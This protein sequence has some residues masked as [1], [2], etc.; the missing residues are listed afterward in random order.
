M[1]EIV[2][3]VDKKDVRLGVHWNNIWI[4][5][6][7]L[8]FSGD[9]S[10]YFSSKFHTQGSL[11][12]GSAVLRDNHLFNQA[13]D[14]FHVIERGL[15]VSLHPKGQLIHV[16]DNQ[17]KKI[18]FSRKM[19]WFP[20]KAPFNLLVLYSPPLDICNPE[21]DKS[22]FYTQVPNSYKDS[23]Q[24]RVDIFPK[25]T[26]EHHPFISSIWIFWGRCPAYLVRVSMNII[27]Q[28]TPVLL[29]WPNDSN[30]RL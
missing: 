3:K 29:F 10:F 6:C 27:K 5:F 1:N 19:E 4:N 7:S 14:Q 13:P 15:H 26:K 30:L 23:I 11:E 20:V 17:N 9:N 8:G 18:L 2:A 24:V 28:R 12:F 16:R 21:K 25:D 22:D